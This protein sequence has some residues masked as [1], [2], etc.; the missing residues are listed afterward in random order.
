MSANTCARIDI[1]STE[2][3]GESKTE[4]PGLCRNEGL[5]V[6]QWLDYQLRLHQT[7]LDAPAAAGDKIDIG[8]VIQFLTV[9]IPLLKS[10]AG[11][12]PEASAVR[13]GNPFIP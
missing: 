9:L 3:T 12:A 1:R 10:A 2:S 13:S 11:A 6:S 8:R 4:W 7:A 5:K